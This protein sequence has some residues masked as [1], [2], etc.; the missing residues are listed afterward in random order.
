MEDVTTDPHAPVQDLT[1]VV[2]PANRWFGAAL[3][4]ACGAAGAYAGSAV[5]GWAA[6]KLNEITE[7]V[8][9]EEF[10]FWGLMS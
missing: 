8:D 3:T 4:A 5:G 10:E 6:D 1:P 9:V 2:P 7:D